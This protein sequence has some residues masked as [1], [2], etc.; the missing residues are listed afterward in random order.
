MTK[1]DDVSR[2]QRKGELTYN[3]RRTL[4]FLNQSC[5]IIQDSSFFSFFLHNAYLLDLKNKK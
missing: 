3:L 1:T 2:S 5:A 4:V